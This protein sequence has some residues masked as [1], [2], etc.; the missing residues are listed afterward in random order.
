MD[1]DRLKLHNELRDEL[2]RR[3]LSN[4]QILDR[5]ILSFIKRRSRIFIGICKKLGS[6]G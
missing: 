1:G 2:F 4:S 5:S 6:T 3:Q